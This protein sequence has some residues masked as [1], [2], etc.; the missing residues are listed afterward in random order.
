MTALRMKHIQLNPPVLRHWL[1]F[2]IDQPA[3]A[4]I[5]EKANLPPPNWIAVNRMNAHAHCGYLLAQPVVTSADGRDHPLRYAAAIESAFNIRLTADP[6][7]SGLIAKNPLHPAWKTQHLHSHPYSLNELAEWVTL[8]KKPSPPLLC[9]GLLRNVSLFDSL[10]YWA[11]RTVLQFKKAGSFFDLWRAALLKEAEVM[12][13]KFPAPLPANE[14][15]SIA[16][17][18]AKWTWRQFNKEHFSE[19]QRSRA[20]RRW[21]ANGNIP[22]ACSKPWEALGI[23]RSTYYTRKKSGLLVGLCHIR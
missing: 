2:D 23:S 3:A 21:T 10:R 6:S 20:H 12:N 5:W 15:R 17:S 22:A 1:L 11:Y 7:Y 19:I 13:L 14:V 8:T 16:K 4:L 9:S 18:I